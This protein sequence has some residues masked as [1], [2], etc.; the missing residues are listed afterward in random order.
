[1]N[2][3]DRTARYLER[4]GEAQRR[5]LHTLGREKIGRVVVIPA[6]AESES[7]FQ[8]LAALAANPPG[9]LSETLVLCVVNNRTPHLADPEAV[10]DNQ[11]TLA[12]LAELLAGRVP[13][14]VSGVL[15]EEIER[16]CGS[17]LR[18]GWIDASSPGREIPDR[19]GGVGTAR[20]IGMDASLSLL[21]GAG[22][23]SGGGLIVCLDADT[24]VDEHYLPALAGHFSA[25]K[26]RAAVAPYAHRM[27]PDPDSM[28]AICSYEIFL[29]AYVIGLAFAGSP[30]AFHAIGSTMA[31]TAQAYVEVRGMNRREAAEDFHF[32]NKLAKGGR[33]GVI[34]GTTVFPSPRRSAR[35][36]FGTGRSMLRHKEGKEEIRLPDPRIFA[37]LRQWLQQMHGDPDR[38]ADEVLSAAQRIHPE[39]ESFL[40]LNRFGGDWD[41]IRR[42][43]SEVRQLLRQFAGWFD[44]LK[45][46]RFVHHLSRTVLPSVPL[47]AGLEGLLAQVGRPLDAL[48]G[49][50]DRDAGPEDR[51]RVLET[52]RSSFPES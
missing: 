32:L 9:E 21:D 41:G 46:L 37:I 22:E 52:L 3:M 45:T 7:L 33:I 35:V 20:K 42:N 36:P 23:G 19:A 17:P 49:L 40:L 16:I 5:P 44:G 50:A 24:L 31:C 15:R 2:P 38:S 43:A 25:G 47:L 6:L 29:R 13:P 1:M 14:F 51:L 28:A 48:Q 30:Y 12:I 26:P 34:S 10:A 27:P 39:L 18:L 8:T 4:Y 11:R